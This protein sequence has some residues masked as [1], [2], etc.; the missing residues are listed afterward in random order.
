MLIPGS[1]SLSPVK[2]PVT[3]KSPNESFVIIV[4]KLLPVPANCFAHT[5]SP[6]EFI[7][8]TKTS[9]LSPVA[10]SV[11]VPTPGSKSLSPVKY[12]VTYKSPDELTDVDLP[13]VQPVPPNWISE[14]LTALGVH[15]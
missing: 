12:P 8:T 10:V 13:S 5:N 7:F 11:A 4:P 15:A 14:G 3:Y 9:A 6:D 1:K 2:Y